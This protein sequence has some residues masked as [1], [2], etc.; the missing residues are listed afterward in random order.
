MHYDEEKTYLTQTNAV[1]YNLCIKSCTQLLHVPALLSRQLQGDDTKI[2]LKDT[3][4]F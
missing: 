1:F 4:V 3:A 2:S